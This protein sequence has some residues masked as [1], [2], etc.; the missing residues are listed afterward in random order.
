MRI[1]QRKTFLQPM[2]AWRQESGPPSSSLSGELSLATGCGCASSAGY[3]RVVPKRH[4]LLPIIAGPARRWPR[5]CSADGLR[6]TSSDICG[7]ATISIAS[8][9]MELIWFLRRPWSLIPPYRALDGQVRKKVG[10]LNRQIAKFGAVNL[11][12][13]IDPAKVEA[14]AQRKSDLQESITQLQKEVDELKAQRKS[15]KRHITYNELP[16]EARF[17]RLIPIP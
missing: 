14:F 1:G 9:T 15:T 3:P 8:S 12:G 11:D 4:S 17:D 6:K 10:L 7:K 5:P 2:C 16:E 13:E